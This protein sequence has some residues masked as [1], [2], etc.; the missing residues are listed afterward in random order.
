MGI[1]DTN[2]A[3]I[4]HADDIDLADLTDV[5]GDNLAEEAVG[6]VATVDREFAP[7]H[8]PVKQIVRQE[9]WMA[10]MA[11]FLKD[12]R[13]PRTIRY[14]TLPGPDLLDVRSLTEVAAPAG[15][16][17]E[18]FGFDSSGT[19][20]DAP[21]NLQRFKMEASLRQAGLI[22][23]NIIVHPDRLEDIALPTSLAA[24]ELG[25]QAAFDIINIDGC[26]HLAYKAPGRVKTTFDALKVLIHHQA[27]R[28]RP[29]LLWITTR[30][31]PEQMSDPMLQF[32]QAIQ[33]N[34]NE[35]EDFTAALCEALGIERANY[36]REAT[37]LWANGGE[38]AYLKLYTVGLSKYLLRLFHGQPNHPG[39][40]ELACSYAYRVRDDAPDMIAVAYRITPK[41]RKLIEPG[42]PQQGH[43]PEVQHALKVVARAARL[44]NIDEA[45]QTDTGLRDDAATGMAKLLDG[46]G[47]NLDDWRDWVRSHPIRPLAI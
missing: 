22:T 3:A 31:S 36:A 29:W 33:S 28:D 10:Q 11:A 24:T 7:W 44:W 15:H 4:S 41:G 46:A 38:E 8:H 12:E 14:F 5:F 39:N 2:G 18:Y 17:I 1:I 23:D 45:I 20:P 19:G 16:K 40:V 42:S 34:C 43:A 32:Q 9:Q 47:Y 21:E 26:D 13:A 35:S 6:P 30:V 37:R 25:S 27:V